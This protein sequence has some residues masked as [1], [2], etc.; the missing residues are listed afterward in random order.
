MTLA[1]SR[2]HRRTSAPSTA[3]RHFNVTAPGGSPGRVSDSQWL[4]TSS[5]GTVMLCRFRCAQNTSTAGRSDDYCR[6]SDVHATQS[7][8]SPSNLSPPRLQRHRF[9]DV[10]LGSVDHFEVWRNSVPRLSYRSR[11]RPVTQT[12][13]VSRTTRTYEFVRSTAARNVSPTAMRSATTILSRTIR[14]S[15]V[16]RSSSRS[17]AGT[18]TS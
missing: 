5:T 3:C 18:S 13:P 2:C 1:P 12:R 7:G 6:W 11:R 4:T 15:P 16:A 8:V 10:A 9:S 17:C 14:L